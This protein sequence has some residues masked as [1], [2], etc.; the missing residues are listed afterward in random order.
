MRL[1][2]GTNE[3]LLADPKFKNAK[4]GDF[5][6]QSMSPCHQRGTDVGLTP[7]GKKPNLGAF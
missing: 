7:R 6:R 4:T 5:R 1:P 3:L 2:P